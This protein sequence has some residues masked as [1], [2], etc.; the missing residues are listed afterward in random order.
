MQAG[1]AT[2]TGNVGV[3]GG[4]TTSGAISAPSLS[5]TG[6]LTAASGS[7]TGNITAG[8]VNSYGVVQRLQ[9]ACTAYP[10]TAFSVGSTL[11]A[12]PLQAAANVSGTSPLQSG[13]LKAPTDGFYTL[14]VS[15]QTGSASMRTINIRLNGTTGA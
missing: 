15:W 7:V 8:S 9:H 6:S 2:I 13:V 12:L 5:L 1:G 4:L 10:T 11:V 14:H 3:T